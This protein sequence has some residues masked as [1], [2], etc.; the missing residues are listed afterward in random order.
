MSTS[1]IAY[2]IVYKNFVQRNNSILFNAKQ[3][4]I[5]S[6]LL[7]TSIVSVFEIDIKL[8]SDNANKV[9]KLVGVYCSHDYMK[10][11]LN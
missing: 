8:F 11:K 7:R 6:K 5:S 9:G 3:T 10:I 2:K 4:I 1:T